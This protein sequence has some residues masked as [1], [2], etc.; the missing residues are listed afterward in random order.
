MESWSRGARQE[1]KLGKQIRKATTKDNKLEK[2]S[3]KANYENKLG[4][5]VQKSN[6][7]NTKYDSKLG[8]LK[9]NKESE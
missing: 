2:Q 1:S 9:A 6:E 5:Q 3:G 4:K 7:K 8:Q